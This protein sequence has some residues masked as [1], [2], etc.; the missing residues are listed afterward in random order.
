MRTAR[1]LATNWIHIVGFYIS[2]YVFGIICKAIG[3]DRFSY[4]SWDWQLVRSLWTIPLLFLIYGLPFIGGFYLVQLFLDFMLFRFSRLRPWGILLLEWLL[5]VP[6]FIYWAFL[7]EYW[8][9]IVLSLSFL[10]T[11]AIRK[12]WILRHRPDHELQ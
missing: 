6:V 11:Q 8:A 4:D 1:I 9:W 12:R 3:L 2:L 10:A 5:I 7:Y